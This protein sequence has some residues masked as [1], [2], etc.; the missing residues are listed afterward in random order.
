MNEGKCVSISW[1]QDSAVVSIRP[2]K[3]WFRK[4]DA[5]FDLTT[6]HHLGDELSGIKSYKSYKTWVAL[7]KTD[8]IQITGCWCY[9]FFG[10]KKLSIIIR[11]T[12][13][14]KNILGKLLVQFP[15]LQPTASNRR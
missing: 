1:N 2:D 14:Y 7:E 13:T 8:V 9:L 15:V 4:I 6:L 5:V 11:R 12:G 10:E 3:D